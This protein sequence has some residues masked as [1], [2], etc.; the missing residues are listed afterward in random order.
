MRSLKAKFTPVTRFPRRYQ[1]GSTR[2]LMTR[3]SPAMTPAVATRA[4]RC[5]ASSRWGRGLIR[6]VPIRSEFEVKEL[7][8]VLKTETRGRDQRAD[9][10]RRDD[11]RE[12]LETGPKWLE[13]RQD[14]LARPSSC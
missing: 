13:S 4:A 5:F 2:R 7:A 12:P 11:V 6:M 1:S 9:H 10:H 3:H 14:R 8:H